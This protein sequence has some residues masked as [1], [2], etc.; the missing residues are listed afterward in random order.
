MPVNYNIA[1]G[2]PQ[3]Q[4]GLQIDP[5]NM[6]AQL[7]QQQALEQRGY[8]QDIAAQRQAEAAQRQ[9]ALF[10][11]QSEQARMATLKAKADFAKDLFKSTVYDQASLDKFNEIT[12]SH[13]G[14]SV[15]HGAKYSPELRAQYLGEEA[16]Q[17][18]VPVPGK[19]GYF[20][21]AEIV[22]GGAPRIIP[23]TEAPQ[24][25]IIDVGGR[26]MAALKGT[27]QVMPLDVAQQ[28]QQ[29]QQAVPSAA[30]SSE[31][32]PGA[33]VGAATAAALLPKFEG[34]TPQAKWDVNANRVG[35]G[36]DTVTTPEGKVIPVTENTKVSRED[37]RRDL[38]R[39]INTEF[40]PKAAAKVGEENWNRLPENVAGALTSVAYNYGNL[41]N[42]VAA[43]VRTGNVNEIANAVESLA[44]DNKGINRGRRLQEAAMIR[45]TEM[46]GTAAVPSFAAS[47]PPA[48]LGVVP[49]QPPINMMAGNIPA[50]NS[51]AAVPPIQVQVQAPPPATAFKTPKTPE[52]LAKEPLQ[53]KNTQIFG[54]LLSA[55]ENMESANILPKLKNEKFL[56]RAE[57]IGE[58][59]LPS[60]V[61]RAINPEAERLRTNFTNII[62]QYIDSIRST[63]QLT[64]G[65]A[66][67]VKELEAKKAKLGSPDMTIDELRD[68]IRSLD[69]N[70]GTGELGK[71]VPVTINVPGHGSV[72]FPNQDAA[73]AFKRDA[74]I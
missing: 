40:I 45:G 51:F 55:A 68:I 46:P 13:F 56:T 37:A 10:G 71:S 66:N 36:S 26:K 54:Q 53:Q 59:L 22:Q 2:V 16:K 34:F 20:A 48:A 57:K 65:E 29:A 70:L 30:P 32:L 64:A 33:R 42:K 23:G 43:A 6:M 38:A 58:A 7:R 35:F 14:D 63:G 8:Y 5:L 11:E 28:A 1:A 61:Q 73:D 15:F 24:F 41:P 74:G 50:Q 39:R 27:N 52:E 4:G 12:K 47:P 18:D 3:A 19:P 17:I 67:T 9:S 21:K 69:K 31:G 25:D 60:S 49:I 62:D 44:D 72:T